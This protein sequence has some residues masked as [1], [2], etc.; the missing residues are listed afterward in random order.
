MQ[1]IHM[2][3]Q[4]GNSLIV[5]LINEATGFLVDLAGNLLGIITG[6]AQVAAQEYLLLVGAVDFR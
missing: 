4:Q 1:L 5:A 6:V 2:L 3:F